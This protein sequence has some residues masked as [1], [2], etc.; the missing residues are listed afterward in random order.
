MLRDVGA[1]RDS[2]VKGKEEHREMIEGKIRYNRF[3]ESRILVKQCEWNLH[4][5]ICS[6]RIT[7]VGA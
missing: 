3:A 2:N 6:K 4:E 5:S 7:R 1:M